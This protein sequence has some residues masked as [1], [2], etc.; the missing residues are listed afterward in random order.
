[1]V[2]RAE[3]ES[4]NQTRHAPTRRRNVSAVIRQY[5]LASKYA[6]AL[7]HRYAEWG[8][9]GIVKVH[10]LGVVFLQQPERVP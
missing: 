9:P 4:V 5:K 10:R 6:E 7:E 2:C 3:H 8:N 1:M